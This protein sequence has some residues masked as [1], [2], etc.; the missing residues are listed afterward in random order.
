M[1]LVGPW[2]S[3][4]STKKK[5]EKITKKKQ[6]E[7]ERGWKER[8][9]LLKELCLPKQTFEQY[10]EWIY[11]KGTKTKERS[12]SKTSP[13]FTTKSQTGISKNEISTRTKTVE[14]TRSHKIPSK[15]DTVKGPCSSKPSP[16]YTGS[17]VIGIGTMHKSNMVPIFSD[18]EAKDI[19]SMRR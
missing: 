4:T 14:E 5:K 8:N 11:G 2:L 7:L 13:T 9:V 17:K 18:D 10:L 16:V 6:E 19:S 15:E 1:S 12:G 3:N